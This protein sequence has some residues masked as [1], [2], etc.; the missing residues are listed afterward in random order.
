METS[1]ETEDVGKG[2]KRKNVVVVVVVV[3][4]ARGQRERL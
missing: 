2:L 4:M 3:V 1:R